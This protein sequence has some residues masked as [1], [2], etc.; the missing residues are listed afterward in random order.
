ML[1]LYRQEYR[2][3]FMGENEKST[4]LDTLAAEIIEQQREYYRKE[5]RILFTIWLITFA[6]L[7]VS[8]GIWM[9]KA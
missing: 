3:N 1:I 6:A 5:R 2:R 8:N 4:K 7:V 9:W